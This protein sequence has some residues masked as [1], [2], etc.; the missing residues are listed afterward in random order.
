MNISDKELEEL[1][2]LSNFRHN[3]PELMQDGDWI[4]YNQLRDKRFEGE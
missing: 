4:R 3:F 2:D 1:T